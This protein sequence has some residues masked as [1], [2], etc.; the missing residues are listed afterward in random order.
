MKIYQ[1]KIVLP[2]YDLCIDY[3]IIYATV[4]NIGAYHYVKFYNLSCKERVYSSNKQHH[5]V[6]YWGEHFLFDSI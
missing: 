6:L 1:I 5:L 3:L 2:F 4:E